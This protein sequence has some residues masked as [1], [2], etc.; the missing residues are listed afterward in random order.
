MDGQLSQRAE[1]NGMKGKI[2]TN[3]DATSMLP[4]VRRIVTDAK[5]C[6]TL[7]ARHERDIILLRKQLEETAQDLSKEEIE[8][9]LVSICEHEDKLTA[10]RKKRAT[11]SQELEDIGAFL[12]DAE[13]G[14]VKFY[15]EIN[16]RIVYYVWQLGEPEVAFW[17]EIEGEFSDRQ[18]IDGDE[19][20]AQS[21]NSN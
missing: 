3:Q 2:F 6:T 18:S 16:S 21:A 5:A 8:P 10:L 4:L 15:G 1:Y 20:I 9:I 12:S 13:T 17:H 11:C 7:I 14:V 19:K